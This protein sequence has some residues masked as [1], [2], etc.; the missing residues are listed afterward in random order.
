MSQET[1]KTQSPIRK[2]ELKRK[3]LME[4]VAA[5]MDIPEVDEIDYKREEKA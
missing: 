3:H 2:A 4:V 5:L 1:T